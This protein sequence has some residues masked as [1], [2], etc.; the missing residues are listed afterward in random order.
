M[1][2]VTAMLNE[3]DIITVLINFNNNSA[4]SVIYMISSVLVV[5]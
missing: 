5:F 2:S 4:L 3:P 1:S